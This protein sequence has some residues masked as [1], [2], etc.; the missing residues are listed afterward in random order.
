D[1]DYGRINAR[2]NIDAQINNSLSFTLDLSY[3]QEEFNR[4]FVTGGGIENPGNGLNNLW[5]DLATAQPILPTELPDPSLGAAYSGFS[6]RNP[7]VLSRRDQLGTYDQI[8][9]VFTGRLGLN[10]A[11]PFVPG[12]NLRAE[13]SIEKLNRGAKTFRNVIDLYSYDPET[14][15]YT[16]EA[17]NGGR[18]NVSDDQFRR[19]QLYP[20][21][22]L[23][24]DKTFGDHSI[25]F[26]GLA[27]QQT[28]TFSILEASRGALLT[29]S[30]PELFVGSTDFQFSNGSSGADIGRKSV[31]SRINYA[32]KDRYLLE[33]TFR[34]DGNVRFAPSQR[35]G[36][37]PSVSAGW[38]ISEEGFF[39][40]SSTID[41][42]KIRA[43]YSQLGDDT[44]NGL[45]GY[46]YLTGYGIQDGDPYLLGNNENFPRIRTLGLVNPALSWEVM[47]LTNFGVEANF[48]EGR[49]GVEFD[50]FRRERD[51]IIATNVEDLPSTFGANLP[52]ENLNSQ[53]SSGFEAAINFQTRI[54]QVRIDL[55][56]NISVVRSKWLEVKSQEDFEDPDQRRLQELDGQPL[57]RFVGYRADGLFMTQEEIDAHEADQDGNGNSTL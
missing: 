55:S 56:P 29:A 35:W 9:N 28:R 50:I 22:S 14:D 49:L 51:G 12:L 6:Q 44:A 46:D 27:E 48:F 30:I 21:V 2:S 38:V 47:T 54:G 4:A 32:Y 5:T 10:Y 45:N 41:F 8:D 7:L 24:Y 1:Y 53:E 43:S 36:Y 13:M 17:T 18:L 3:R 42:L 16:L 31:V 34:A 20:L 39:N 52:V 33:G 40:K 11:V 37:F 25:K 57:N 26:L 23:T 15:S 19:T